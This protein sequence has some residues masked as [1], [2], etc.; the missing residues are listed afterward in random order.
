MKNNAVKEVIIK[1]PNCGE[2]VKI[3]CSKIPQDVKSLDIKCDKCGSF[4]KFK[5]KNYQEQN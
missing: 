3:D 5:N 4:I 1:C 2:E